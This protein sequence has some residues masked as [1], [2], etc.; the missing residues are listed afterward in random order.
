MYTLYKPVIQYS[1]PC[2][3]TV[4]KFIV[5]DWGFIVDSGMRL[6]YW[7]A[8]LFSLAGRYDNP[9]PELTLSPQVKDYEFG[10]RAGCWF[11]AP[12][13]PFMHLTV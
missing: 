9:M 7:P 2:V 11:Y 10:L 1:R 12:E 3:Y 6:W 13:R 8:S 4:A 5:P